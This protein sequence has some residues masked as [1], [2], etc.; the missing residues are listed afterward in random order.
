MR[1]KMT[2]RRTLVAAGGVALGATAG[3]ALAA[4]GEAEVAETPAEPAP[5]TPAPATAA[6]VQAAEPPPQQKAVEIEFVH[7]HVSGPR[8]E[9]MRWGLASFASQFPEINVRFVVQPADFEDSFAIQQA[10]NSQGEVALLSGAF[11]MSWVEGGAF[12]QI[13]EALSKNP[14]WDPSAQF[15]GPDAFSINFWNRV[16][17]SHLEPISGP[18]FGLPYQG[19]MIGYF[20]NVDMM[21]KAGIEF[22]TVGKWGI[23]T[24]YLEA[25]K[26]GTDPE[27][28]QWGTRGLTGA[29]PHGL[30]LPLA[31]SDRDDLMPVYNSDATRF[32]AY[33]EGGDRGLQFIID[34]ARTHKV[35]YPPG[36]YREIAG[37]FGDP[38][39][40]GKQMIWNAGGA[41]GTLANRIKDRFEWSMGPIPEGRNGEPHPNNFDGQPHLITNTAERRGTVEQ[42]VELINFFVGPGVQ[43]RIAID[44]GSLPYNKEAI[45]SAE[46]AAGPPANHSLWNDQAQRTDHR[47]LQ[48][49]HPNWSEMWPIFRWDKT[50]L[51]E[52]TVEEGRMRVTTEADRFL[53][54]NH[55]NW[56]SLKRYAEAAS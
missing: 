2:R 13:N 32:E 55:D 53:E 51:G 27:I 16:P 7:D 48:W 37:E 36:D 41:V 54:R 15:F 18:T 3:I 4:C 31:L 49:A 17:S 22:P 19:N 10:A 47:H 23:E 11:F 40:A 30:F 43:G 12:T 34:M 9:A 25:L 20:F 5:A 56:A 33:D 8:G 50:F 21:T 6:P 14:R 39:S 1:L 46:M 26:K 42:A 45:A 24:E 44:R 38:F 35:S 29:W 52:E 28:G